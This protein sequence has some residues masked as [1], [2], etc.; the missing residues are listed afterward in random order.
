[1]QD[2]QKQTGG[3]ADT[4]VLYVTNLGMWGVVS[5][6]GD[7][8]RA[9]RSRCTE[10]LVAHEGKALGDLLCGKHSSSYADMAVEGCRR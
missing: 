9:R 3:K 6:T 10:G 5:R 8:A 1:M 7:T 4:R 2:V